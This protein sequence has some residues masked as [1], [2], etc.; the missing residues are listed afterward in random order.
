V[1]L[2]GV[3][4]LVWFLFLCWRGSVVYVFLSFLFCRLRNPRPS[5]ESSRTVL[6]MPSA[7]YIVGH[8]LV[9][10]MSGWI[11]AQC[12]Y[13]FMLDRMSHVPAFGWLCCRLCFCI[14][15]LLIGVALQLSD[16]RFLFWCVLPPIVVCN[17]VF[18]LLYF[19]FLVL[20]LVRMC[21]SLFVYFNCA[22][23]R[24]GV[25]SC[26]SQSWVLFGCVSWVMTMCRGFCLLRFFVFDFG[27]V[28]F[29]VCGCRRIL[30]FCWYCIFLFRVSHVVFFL[31][32]IP[33]SLGLVILI[34]DRL[35]NVTWVVARIPFYPWSILI[36]GCPP[37]CSIALDI[38]IGVTYLFSRV[39]VL[40]VC[41]VVVLCIFLVPGVVCFL[42][43][44][45]GVFG[46]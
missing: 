36:S 34:T 31:S 1:E 29:R 17:C 41:L 8:L 40:F 14:F 45:F 9:W 46:L 15:F 6:S 38:Q 42:F 21:C 3:V 10:N 12:Q 11:L 44:M 18:C 30:K 37:F 43:F 20:C 27:V 2:V 4:F 19:F 5:C 26:I 16:S 28:R 35:Q 32:V 24:C 22:F 23:C 25:W 7:V 13:E 39:C 33:R